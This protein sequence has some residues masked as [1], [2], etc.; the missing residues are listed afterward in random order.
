MADS[1]DTCFACKKNSKLTDEHI[2][3][4]AIG[5]KLKIKI[6]CEACNS[7]FGSSIDNEISNRF[8]FLATILDVKRD[9]GSL[10]PF[11]VQELTNKINLEFDGQ[12]LIRKTPIVM[13]QA[14]KERKLLKF[15]DVI[16]RSKKELMNIIKSIKKKYNIAEEFEVSDNKH[17]GPTDVKHEL[18][19]D[20]KLIRRAVT[21]MAYSF[22]CYK[23]PPEITLSD[24]FANVRQY[25]IVGD[26]S[27]LACANFTHTQFMTDYTRPLHK[28]QIALNRLDNSVVGYVMLFGIFRYTVLLSDNY[29]S[30]FEWPCLDYTFDPVRQEE[31]MGNPNFRH[32][33]IKVTDVLHPKHSKDFVIDEV[34]KGF[35]IL[36][37]YKSQIEFMKVE[38]E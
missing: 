32:R 12:K 11:D 27:D 31:V 3:P 9:R 19:F 20:N 37:K 33:P 4:Q 14:D 23:I 29:I 1:N 18:I 36:N 15:A 25:F 6:Y 16:A 2:I 5:G 35:K 10:Q 21:K 8:G 26:C 24:S 7:E 13:I 38:P 17:P 22:M 34:T 28:I 30:R